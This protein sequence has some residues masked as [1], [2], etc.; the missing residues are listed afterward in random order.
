MLAGTVA[1]PTESKTAGL[2]KAGMMFASTFTRTHLS[3]WLNSHVA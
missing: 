2:M 3:A 1:H